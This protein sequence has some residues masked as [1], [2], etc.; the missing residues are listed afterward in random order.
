MS[1]QALGGLAVKSHLFPAR[2]PRCRV[3]L[4]GKTYHGYLGHMGMHT[5]A[6]RYY[7]GDTSAAARQLAYNGLASQDPMPWN[8]AFQR[9]KKSARIY[10]AKEPIMPTDFSQIKFDANKHNYFL[11]DKELRSVTNFIKVFQKPFDRDRIAQR[12]A[13]KENRSVAEVLAEWEAAGERARILGTTV[14]SHIEKVLRGEQN[15]QLSLDPFLSL[16]TK[17]PEIAAFDAFWSHLSPAVTCNRDRIEWVIGDT[18]LGLAGMVDAVFYSLDTGKY[19]IWDWKTGKFDL[20][21][22]W[23]N[24]LKPFDYL[25][26]SKLNIYSLQVSLYRLIIERNTGLELG[27]SYIVHLSANGYQVHRAIDLRERLMDWMEVPF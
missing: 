6:D 22:Q 5:Y 4:A 15:G 9:R 3:S 24:L 12:T 21:N 16:N 10:Q 20:E 23:E 26:A 2:C 17:L 11:G 7:C 8:G 1:P 14:H 27:D 18:D 19:H 13:T 25:S